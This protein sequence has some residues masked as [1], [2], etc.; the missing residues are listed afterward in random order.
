MYQEFKPR[1]LA[2]LLSGGALE[3]GVLLGNPPADAISKLR[4]ASARTLVTASWDGHVHLYDTAANEL[5]GRYAHRAAVL[6]A[7]VLDGGASVVSAGVDRE[8]RHHDWATG[9]D[10]CLGL[11]DGP[12]RAVE[13]LP[14]GGL[15]SGSWDR[16]LRLWDVR[17]ARGCEGVHEQP[18]K[19]YAMAVAERQGLPLVI[20][21]TAGRHVLILDPRNLAEPLQR[22]ESSL[23]SQTRCLAASNDGES[24]AVGSVDGRVAMEYV[25]A[26][27]ESQARK[28]AFKCHRSTGAPRG[29]PPHPSPPLGARARLAHPFPRA[30]RRP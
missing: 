30:R 17:S 14:G 1:L 24:Y 20:V 23:K 25:D 7:A 12:V 19:V 22:R 28:Y 4:F 18:D 15:V 9:A 21:G 3:A 5:R 6:D 10:R 2:M 16:T 13:A 29:P 27:E 11:H 26:S 8:L